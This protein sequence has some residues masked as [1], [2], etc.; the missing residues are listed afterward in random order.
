M[1]GDTCQSGGPVP[2]FDGFKYSPRFFPQFE[3]AFHFFFSLSS[4]KYKQTQ[5]R[6]LIQN[7][8]LLQQNFRF[9]FVRIFSSR[10]GSILCAVVMNG[11]GTAGEAQSPVQ[12]LEDP[13][14]CRRRGRNMQTTA[15]HDRSERD[16]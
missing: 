9:F 3:T 8:P 10:S 2:A 15:M 13:Q 1:C 4:R 16:S 6:L 12:T 5:I 14:H 11:G 7:S